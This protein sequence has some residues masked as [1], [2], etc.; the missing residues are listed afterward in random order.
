MLERKEKS[1]LPVILAECDSVISFCPQKLSDINTLKGMAF[2]HFTYY[3]IAEN[4]LLKAVRNN[5]S[6]SIALYYLMKIYEKTGEKDKAVSLI[7]RI[8]R[9]SPDVFPNLIE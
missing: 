8:I 2:Y 5:E 9:F 3:I 6:N 1:I 4:Y 7:P